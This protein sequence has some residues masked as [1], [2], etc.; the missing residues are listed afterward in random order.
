MVDPGNENSHINAVIFL[1]ASRRP[2]H[3]AAPILL[4]Q[5]LK[6]TAFDALRTEHGIGYSVGMCCDV[7]PQQV[8]LRVYAQ[9][10]THSCL[11]AAQIMLDFMEQTPGIVEKFRPEELEEHRQACIKSIDRTVKTLDDYQAWA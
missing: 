10:S 6:R 8:A 5:I 7:L 2:E 11:E 1:G 9:S 4:N 3:I